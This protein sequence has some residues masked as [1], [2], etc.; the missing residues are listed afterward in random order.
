[1]AIV[2]LVGTASN[3]TDVENV[4][5]GGGAT[6]LTVNGVP[7]D[8]SVTG[9][10]L[11]T[12]VIFEG[13]QFASSC[14]LTADTTAT[15]SISVS[16]LA[17]GVWGENDDVIFATVSVDGLNGL[18]PTPTNSP[19][20]GAIPALA[21]L[22]NSMHR[23]SNM[24]FS[25]FDTSPDAGTLSWAVTL[26]SGTAIANVRV[27]AVIIGDQPEVTDN[28][29]SII[30][31]TLT[32]DDVACAAPP[33]PGVSSMFDPT[34]GHTY[35]P[36]VVCYALAGPLD[37]FGRPINLADNTAVDVTDGAELY[38]PAVE[39]RTVMELACHLKEI[40]MDEIRSDE[41]VIAEGECDEQRIPGELRG[42]S[43][44]WIKS[45]FMSPDFDE[46]I[47]LR[48]NLYNAGALAASQPVEG[49]NVCAC[50]AGCRRAGWWML[51]WRQMLSTGSANHQPL[52][53]PGGS[54]MWEVQL[55]TN[56]YVTAGLGKRKTS[57][58]SRLADQDDPT[59]TV[60]ADRNA[61]IDWSGI[62]VPDGA[63]GFVS[64]L[65]AALATID[66]VT[67][68]LSTQ[69][70]SELTR[71]TEVP[72]PNAGC[73]LVTPRWTSYLPTP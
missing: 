27:L 26:P 28:Q 36:G 3:P 48:R 52:M 44:E 65:P 12:G 19:T 42:F 5:M 2:N 53:G 23:G 47:G 55:Y 11:P 46:L 71:Y 58:I 1:M 39:K 8:L 51:L 16:D 38:T 66:G 60:R 29:I 59:F 35:S 20:D 37:C 22:V 9:Q 69:L 49:F 31:P 14:V 70:G 4:D 15:I 13:Y 45:R 41:T 17:A 32:F 63:G 21:G 10:T 25:A 64:L 30:P 57:Q 50:G 43:G 40:S 18:T 7:D 54:A 33:L 72:P 34:T 73:D 68:D 24:G 61:A 62:V 56:L 6:P 67:V